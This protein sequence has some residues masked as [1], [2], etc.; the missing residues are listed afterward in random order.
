L[1]EL[2][3]RA[4]GVLDEPLTAPGVT[5]KH[6]LHVVMVSANAN[7]KNALHYAILCNMKKYCG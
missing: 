1:Q 6:P 7:F 4:T 3:Q 2:K 5:E